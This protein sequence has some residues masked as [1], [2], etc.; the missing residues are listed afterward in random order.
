MENKA[1]DVPVKDA[2]E[3]LLYL[4]KAGLQRIRLKNRIS[5]QLLFVL[6]FQVTDGIMIA[7]KEVGNIKSR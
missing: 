3:A 5:L 2:S 6:S 7:C 4:M 1:S